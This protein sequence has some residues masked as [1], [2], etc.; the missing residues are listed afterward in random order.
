[1]SEFLLVMA[2]AATLFLAWVSSARKNIQAEREAANEEVARVR[3]AIQ[4]DLVAH[5]Q[6]MEL[7]KKESQEQRPNLASF[8]GSISKRRYDWFHPDLEELRRTKSVMDIANARKMLRESDEILK[9]HFGINMIRQT[10]LRSGRYAGQHLPGEHSFSDLM[11][12][13]NNDSPL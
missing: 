9:S 10:G 12:R 2:L 3:N 5:R 1:M 7:L 13:L 6:R 11:K 8:G 4:S